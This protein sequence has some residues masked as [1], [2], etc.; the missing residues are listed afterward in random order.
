MVENFLP[1]DLQIALPDE[2]QP[3]GAVLRELADEIKTRYRNLIAARVASYALGGSATIRHTFSLTI[4]ALDD[5]ADSLFY[6]VHFGE[7]YPC[8]I[9]MTGESQSNGRSY[10]NE[11]MFR[12]QLASMFRQ[13]DVRRR[14]REWENFA[15]SVQKG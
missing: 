5:Y 2:Q 10:A 9:I 13:E 11:E 14:L 3:P 8:Q 1:D 7:P 15:R 12:R 4:P 6:V